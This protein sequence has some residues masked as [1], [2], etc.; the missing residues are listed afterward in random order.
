MLVVIGVVVGWQQARGET[1]RHLGWRVPT[2]KIAIVVGILY[3]ALG[4]AELRTGRRHFTMPWQRPVMALI[5]I[6]LA[7]GGELA[8]RGHASVWDVGEAARVL[9][10]RPE[11]TWRE[12]ERTPF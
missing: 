5:G 9:G 12:A 7:F 8:V 11:F 1:L 6:V 4:A 2:R 10:R 3:G